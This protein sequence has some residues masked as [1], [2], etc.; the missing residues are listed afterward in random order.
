MLGKSPVERM[1]ERPVE[2]VITWGRHPIDVLKDLTGSAEADV[3]T[4]RAYC[5]E[6]VLVP[7]PNPMDQVFRNLG[8]D[9]TM[10][11]KCIQVAFNK[12]VLWGVVVSVARRQRL[13]SH[14][15]R[16]PKCRTAQVQSLG[17]LPA[18]WKCR[19]CRHGFVYEPLVEHVGKP[20]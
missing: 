19:E 10:V 18:Q 12:S 20:E 5:D 3:A 4:L 16:C 9:P 17:G 7:R 14:A 11:T 15:P 2:E 13:Y 6:P 1:G 8:V